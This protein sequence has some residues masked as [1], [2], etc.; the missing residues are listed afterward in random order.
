MATDSQKTPLFWRWLLRLLFW[1][2]ILLAFLT[3]FT[4]LL[5]AQLPT[6]L[7]H[8]QQQ[9]SFW[10]VGLEIKQI[11]AQWYGWQ[12]VI[13][14]S[15]VRLSL[16]DQ[17][18]IH[19]RSVRALFKPQILWRYEMDSIQQLQV[20]LYPFAVRRLADQRWAINDVVLP[21]GSAE[22]SFPFAQLPPMRVYIPSVKFEDSEHE[23]E[24]T[25][26]QLQWGVQRQQGPL[27]IELLAHLQHSGGSPL[28]LGLEADNT[29]LPLLDWSFRWHARAGQVDLG[30]LSAAWK[31]TQDQDK[32]VGEMAVEA[33]GRY[34]LGLWEQINTRLQL[35][36]FAWQRGELKTPPVD[37]DSKWQWQ[38]REAGHWRAWLTDSTLSSGLWERQGLELLAEWQ[39]NADGL[40]ESSLWLNQLDQDVL[41]FAQG[42]L[43]QQARTVVAGLKPHFQIH[44]LMLQYPGSQLPWGATKVS[45]K[46]TDW[47]Q[48]QWR[49]YPAL[50]NWQIEV[51]GTL[52]QLGGRFQSSNSRIQL[53]KIFRHDLALD[54]LSG[55]WQ[56]QFDQQGQFQH[57]ALNSLSW[58]NKDVA[59]NGRLQLDWADGKPQLYLRAASDYGDL[60]RISAYLP[61]RFM[62]DDLV[63]WLD[64]GVREGQIQRADILYHSRL[65][66][67]RTLHA[68]QSGVLVNETQ[69][70]EAVVQHQPG[71]PLLEKADVS[72]R[73]EG[74]SMA[75]TVPSA[76]SAGVQIKDISIQA[77][78]L[79]DTDLQINLNVQGA[80]ETSRNLLRQSPLRRYF[81]S[82]DPAIEALNG[83]IDL[84]LNLGIALGKSGRDNNN[85]GIPR[86]KGALTLQNLQATAPDW[87]L[88]ISEANGVL[89]FNDLNLRAEDLQLN[90]WGQPQKV[91]LRTEAGSSNPV[92][93]IAAQGPLQLEPFTDGVPE[94]IRASI[95][96]ASQWRT[97]LSLYP[98]AGKILQLRAE[99][100]L[101]GTSV[102]LPE[103]LNK[104]AE[105]GS[106]L[107]WEMDLYDSQDLLYKLSWSDRLNHTGLLKLARDQAELVAG[108]FHFGPGSVALPAS[109]LAFS[110]T[111]NALSV[112]KWQN[113]LQRF[114]SKSDPE[115]PLRQLS[116]ID[117]LVRNL[118]VSG[119][120]IDNLQIVADRYGDVLVG[121][122]QSPHIKGSF[123]L[124]D[125]PTNNQPQRYELDYLV[126]ESAENTQVLTAA[127]E[128]KLAQILPSDLAPIDLTLKTL[129]FDKRRF[130]DGLFR[131]RWQS[132][133]YVVE[134]VKLY[135]E[136]LELQLQGAWS[137]DPQGAQQ[138]T[139]LTFKLTGDDLGASLERL[140][141]GRL[142]AG[143]EL[144][145][146]GELKWSA[147]LLSP[148][149]QNLSGSGNFLLKDGVVLD[150]EPGAGRLVGLFSLSAL[151]R[152]LTLDFKDLVVEGLQFDEI[153]GRLSLQNGVVETLNTELK[154]PSVKVI[155]GGEIDLQ[156]REYKELITV[157]PRVRDTLP[158]LGAAAASNQVGWA[159]LLLQKMFKKPI[160]ESVKLRYTLTGSWDEPLL[161]RFQEQ[162]ATTGNA[163]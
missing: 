80:A 15:D 35:E 155:V 68:S 44:D 121:S 139:A 106:R 12:P 7:P 101:E 54:Q 37:V 142:I 130:H 18:A 39:V 123:E 117:L 9:L 40:Q 145:F 46:L 49:E 90:L 26:H 17:P 111:I 141:S 131:G 76:Q 8:L 105:Q 5:T 52:A 23:R 75:I 122:L 83:D 151:P 149:W 115:N 154:G 30:A 70:R 138:Q 95:K 86:V 87:R 125:A 1:V 136:D 73:F 24:L 152:R 20:D 22:F 97:Q 36:A 28:R 77:A 2:L 114:Q 43:P 6:L 47:K 88:Q 84:D 108:H 150:A 79:F 34:H 127:E 119:Q 10:G 59:L 94:F 61:V 98:Q 4:R 67:T 143:G 27:Q 160:E 25:L 159:L 140:Q 53:P 11:E 42:L 161:E 69:V 163:Q 113:Y 109:M 72:L 147:P 57:L 118:R 156:N 71:W 157:I 45:A 132:E 41:S 63:Q 146:T 110:G 104:D 56:L 144:E 100:R 133:S 103:P 162:P 50:E 21:E 137:A 51:S 60:R 120:R 38:E 55:E 14:A 74:V 158:L 153:Q 99:S 64:N 3:A 66:S 96:G 33:W 93:H 31:P 148:N 112:R 91:S 107:V 19:L 116:R 129:L 126:L 58:R 16:P 134:Q 29:H 135:Q 82:V 85:F 13:Q 32:V 124:P 65:Q 92:V 62:E 128:Q 48:Q 78:N 81:R 89:H 102:A